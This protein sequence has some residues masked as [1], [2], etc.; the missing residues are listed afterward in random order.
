MVNP[1]AKDQLVVHLLQQA[2]PDVE[3]ALLLLLLQQ[4]QQQ[5]AQVIHIM[6]HRICIY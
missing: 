5:H 1:P 6:V 3:L 4:Q 2:S